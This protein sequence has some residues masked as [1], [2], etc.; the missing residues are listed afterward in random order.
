MSLTILLATRGRP[1]LCCET[2]EITL[3]NI[4]L[5][6]TKLVVAM[7]KDDQQT[8]DKL[9]LFALDHPNIKLSVE[10]REDSLG[11]KY[12]RA[13][14]YPAQVYLPMVD[15][16]PHV[17]PGFDAMICEAA[18][19]FPDNIGVVYNEL[20][21]ASFPGINGI[22]HG[23][24]RKMGF[25]YPPWFPYWFVDHWLD[26]IA[27]MINRISF[28]DV[29]LDRLKRPGTQ[30]CRDLKFWTILFDALHLR[31]RECAREIIESN[32]F[33]EPLWRK[34]LSLAHY[35]LIEFRSKWVNDSMRQD[36]KGIEAQGSKGIP[37]EDRYQRVKKRGVELL[38][39]LIPELTAEEARKAA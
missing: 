38:A 6:S 30:D 20:A 24:A 25:I 21:N 1:D 2:L 3:R 32:D 5:P 14:R 22:T 23:L 19:L 36:P 17:T 29:R 37:D 8:V 11:E 26:D 33:I 13:L 12:D 9:S 10:Q 7:D 16:A 35:P 28:V 18:A 31:R 27:R 34:K 39:S 15:Y 4:A